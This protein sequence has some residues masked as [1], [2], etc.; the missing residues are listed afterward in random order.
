M[1]T[2]PALGP[3][4]DAGFLVRSASGRSRSL[5]SASEP[6][7]RGCPP[8]TAPGDHTTRRDF[9]VLMLKINTAEL[10]LCRAITTWPGA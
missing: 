2:L 7:K 6:A 3:A 4:L 5:A 10:L 1:E 8:G 9:E